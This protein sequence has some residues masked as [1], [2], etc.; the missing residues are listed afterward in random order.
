MV[1]YNSQELAPFFHC[2]GPWME[3]SLSSKKAELLNSEPPYYGL[4]VSVDPARKLSLILLPGT[5]K[6]LTC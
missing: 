2:V 3:P 5:L 6:V 1:S 4:V